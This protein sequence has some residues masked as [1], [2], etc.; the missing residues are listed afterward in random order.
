MR[1]KSTL[2]QLHGRL[3]LVWCDMCVVHSG[4]VACILPL[5][6]EMEMDQTLYTLLSL[7]KETGTPCW[8]VLDI[9]A[10]IKLIIHKSSICIVCHGDDASVGLIVLLMT[11]CDSHSHIGW[12]TQWRPPTKWL[13]IDRP[14]FGLTRTCEHTLW[15]IN[16][17]LSMTISTWEITSKWWSFYFP[18]DFFR[19]CIVYP[20]WYKRLSVSVGK[21]IIPFRGFG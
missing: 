6:V 5:H 14:H 8:A 4:F 2:L 19:L 13:M 9:P 3:M 20:T 1:N 16:P 17:E 12:Y 21:P 18:V 7:Q 10:V 15:E 11:A